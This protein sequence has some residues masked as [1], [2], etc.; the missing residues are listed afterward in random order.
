MTV[1]LP[2]SGKTHWAQDHMIQNPKKCYNLLSTNSILNCMRVRKSIKSV[3]LLT[4]K[5]IESHSCLLITPP[6]SLF[7]C[8]IGASW[9]QSQRADAAAGHSVRQSADQKSCNQEKELHPWSGSEE[10]VC[11]VRRVR[12]SATVLH[13]ICSCFRLQGQHLSICPETQDALFPWLPAKSSGGVSTWWGVEETSRTA[14]RA[15]GHRT[16][17]NVSS[18]S[19][20][21]D[22]ITRV[23]TH[24]SCTIMKLMFSSL[25]L[26]P[27]SFTLPEQGEH[28][29]EVMFV[30]LSSDE[31]LKLLTHYK[32]EARQLLPTPPKRKKH[33]QGNQNRPIHQCGKR[34][35]LHF[36]CCLLRSWS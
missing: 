2:G 34:R 13:S 25:F 15:G 6:F 8:P 32:E 36:C 26:F 33:K 3:L 31:A 19:Q 1:G 23:K 30:E 4:G 9:S 20:R 14:A 35:W 18:Q 10:C 22:W 24:Y 17:G 21:W 27:V 11:A 7:S 5:A 12:T 28:V 29:D 16:S